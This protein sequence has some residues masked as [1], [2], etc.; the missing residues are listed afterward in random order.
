LFLLEKVDY[1]SVL[2]GQLR[3][4]Y[5]FMGSQDEKKADKRWVPL[6]AGLL[7]GIIG[8]FVILLVENNLIGAAG[9]GLIIFL[10]TW[11]NLKKYYSPKL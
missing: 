1:E 6:V 11:R 5:G 8:L 4:V 7:A 9:V 10:V 3:G 2:F